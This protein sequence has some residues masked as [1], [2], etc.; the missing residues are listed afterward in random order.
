MTNNNISNNIDGREDSRI[1]I[2][3]V[4]SIYTWVAGKYRWTNIGYLKNK[5][6]PKLRAPVMAFGMYILWNEHILLSGL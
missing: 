3:R 1:G 2:N 5:I 4:C 6:T